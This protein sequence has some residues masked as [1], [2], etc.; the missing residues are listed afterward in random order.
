MIVCGHVDKLTEQCL[1]TTLHKDLL[2]PNAESFPQGHRSEVYI[3]LCLLGRLT[4]F[5]FCSLIQFSCCC[6]S[7]ARRSLSLCCTCMIRN[8]Y[9][10]ET[11]V[12]WTDSMRQ[13][14]K[15][16]TSSLSQPVT[17]L[18]QRGSVAAL[19][20]PVTNPSVYINFN[21]PTPF[22][23]PLFPTYFSDTCF[24]PLISY[25]Q[26]GIKSP[27]ERLGKKELLSCL[28]SIKCSDSLSLA[29]R[30]HAAFSLCRLVF[31][32]IRTFQVSNRPLDV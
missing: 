7:A 20:P 2:G 32:S 4:P 10:W 21:S 9:L 26:T 1:N 8:S 22:S 31:S 30:L 13:D 3:R 14:F 5:F 24:F 6:V 27:A 16:Q 25:H 28:A 12:S 17:V 23:V 18:L 11:F 15:F 29:G 19:T